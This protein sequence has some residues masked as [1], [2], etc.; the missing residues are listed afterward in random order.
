MDFRRAGT[1]DEIV[2]I[3]AEV[4]PDATLLAG[5]TDVMVQYLRGEIAPKLLVHIEQVDE[6]A[7][8]D[9]ADGRVDIGALTTHLTLSEDPVIRRTVPGL[10]EAASQVGGHQTQAV[11]TVGGNLCNASPAA[12]TAPPLLVADAELRLRSA[13]GTRTVP[14]DRFFLGRR[15]T[16]RRPDEVLT[17]IA[18]RPLP[19]HAGETYLKV[20]RRGAMEVAIVGLAARLVLDDD[21]DVVTDARLA[22][23][24]MAPRPL[25]LPD[26]ERLLVGSRGEPEAVAAAADAVQETT[27]PID[28]ARARA[29]YRRR[30]VP[31]LLAEAVRLCM[32]RARGEEESWS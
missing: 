12:D 18:V 27:E 1:T 15:H 16:A 26:A 3:L 4:G 20:G 14:L 8:V 6:L 28:D 24:S 13:A 17:S 2:S 23:C 9:E 31:R 21:G 5:G 19:S 30:L 10:A 25:R 22:V 7:G 11:G 29:A 32:R